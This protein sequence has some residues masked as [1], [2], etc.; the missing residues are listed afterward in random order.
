MPPPARVRSCWHFH[1]FNHRLREMLWETPQDGGLAPSGMGY[2]PLKPRRLARHSPLGEVVPKPR[3]ACQR[4]S[5]GLE[6]IFD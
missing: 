4:R 5:G 1:P 6:F 3:H 2:L